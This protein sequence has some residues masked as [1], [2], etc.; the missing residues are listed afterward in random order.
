[1]PSRRS[2]DDFVRIGD[3]DEGF[4]LLVVLGDEAVD[5]GLK[6][7]DAF[8]DAAFQP[9]PGEDGEEALDGVEPAGGGGGEVECPAWVTSQPLDHLGVLVGGVII[10][11]GVNGFFCGN[12]ALDGVQKANELLMS[13]T[14]HAASG[15]LALQHV[16]GGEQR[17]RAVAVVVIGHRSGASLLHGEA[18]L[19]SIQSLDLGLL[20]DAE[21]H[22]VS[23]RIDIETDDVADLGRE[24]RVIGQ[25]EGAK[26]VGGQ[27]MGAPDALGRSQADGHRP[28]HHPTG[29]MGRLSRWV[30]Q[31]QGHDPFGH[32]VG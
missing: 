3:P 32:F 2:G 8:E 29:P 1:M 19:G 24:L 27:A 10:H 20:V 25:L 31:G 12:L 5:S 13:V 18:R 23:G 17:G 26:T 11:D 9:P 14:L 28:G 30:A 4:G 6:I 7:D 16:K 22:R 21:N 15:D